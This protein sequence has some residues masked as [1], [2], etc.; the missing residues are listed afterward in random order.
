MALGWRVYGIGVMAMGL[1]CLAFGDFDPG[2]PVPDEDQHLQGLGQ[3]ARVPGGERG[4]REGDQ[5][6]RQRSGDS[7]A[8]RGHGGKL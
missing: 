7:Q 8:E 5:G 2:Q 4:Q 6:R 1:V 3:P